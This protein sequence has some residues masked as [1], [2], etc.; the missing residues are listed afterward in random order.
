MPEPPEPRVDLVCCE[1]GSHRAALPAALT[2]ALTRPCAGSQVVAGYVVDHV[3]V[4]F[5][6]RCAACAGGQSERPGRRAG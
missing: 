6:G 3:D 5:L 4:T 1:C 2:A